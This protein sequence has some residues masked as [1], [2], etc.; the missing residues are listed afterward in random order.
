[1]DTV[2]LY[3]QAQDEFDAVMAAVPPDQWD[4]P[5]EC[6]EW[7]VRDVAGHVIWGQRQLRAWATGEDYADRSGAPGSPQPRVLAAT[8][9]VGTWRQA[10]AV[11][12]ASLTEDNLARTA[13][14]PGLGEIPVAALVTLLIT[15]H[16]AHTWD[17]GHALGMD[18]R[19]DPVLVSVAF[20]WA[21]ANV[22][23]RPGF[24][25]PELTP[26]ADADERT[27]MLA[28]IGRAA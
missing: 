17:I 4:A 2:E 21:R 25:G 6:S 22:V 14:L 24:F 1:M 18:V 9:P 15:D 12:V 19:Q 27:R 13:T 23:R 11:S 20:D 7:S 26:P 28:F 3:R 8:D 5:S 16:V 10:R